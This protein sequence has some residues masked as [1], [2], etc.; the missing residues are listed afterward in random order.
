MLYVWLFRT[1]CVLRFAFL[2]SY[3]CR[4]VEAF[5]RLEETPPQKHFRASLSPLS[6][7][8][9]NETALPPEPVKRS[10]FA[11]VGTSCSSS[12]S[13]AS[14]GSLD[15][16]TAAAKRSP[17]AATIK[18]LSSYGGKIL[19]RYPDGKLRYIGGDTRVL[20]VDRSVPFSE[21]QE[22]MREMCGWVAV[23]L[24]CQLPTEDLDALVS[25]KS[26][27]DLANIM[28]EYDL[29]GREKIRA[30][31][32]PP[33]SKPRSPTHPAATATALPSGRPWILS[34]KRCIHQ[35]SDPMRYPGRY[36]KSG[37]ISSGDIR[38]RAHHHHPQHHHHHHHLHGHHAIPKPCNYLVHQGS[39]WQ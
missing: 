18:F 32:F 34:E 19:P 11:M 37:A 8:T 7:P 17:S 20:A 26:D 24:R 6:P 21:L 27:E 16:E 9:C 5:A 28:E 23:S 36:G 1:P 38:Y 15:A 2:L 25:V 31:L 30:F 4:E 14:F 39:Q 12:S 10:G 29:A 35:I 33:S 22:K 13:C 3:K